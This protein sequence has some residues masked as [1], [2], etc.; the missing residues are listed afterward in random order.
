VVKRYRELQSLYQKLGLKE[1][2]KWV[3]DRLEWIE[4][5]E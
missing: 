2:A 3:K 4:G 5:A 1:D